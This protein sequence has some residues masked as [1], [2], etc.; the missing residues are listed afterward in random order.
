M[1][2]RNFVKGLAAS[3]F[4]IHLSPKLGEGLIDRFRVLEEDLGKARDKRSF[5]RRVRQEFL[6]N[7]DL[8]YLNCG[9]VGSSPRVVVDA[10][11][12]YMYE[13]EGDPLH[14]EWG[15]IGAWMEDVRSRAAE[16]IGAEEREIILTRNTTEGMNAVATGL[17]LKAGDEVL[18]T[19]HEHG[20]GMVCWQYLARHFGV[21]VRYIKMPDPV[22]NKEQ[23]LD[24]VEQ[25][26]T[27]KT[28]V[29]SFSHVDTITGLQMPIA[30]IARITRARDILLVC[31]GAQAPGMLDVDVM[32]LGVDTYASSSQKWMLS[33]KGCGLLY[34]R[35]GVQDRVQPVM[36]YD[37]Y[38][39]YTASMGTRNVPQ[40]LGHGVAMDFHNAIGRAHVEARIRQLNSLM[41]ERLKQIPALRLLTPEQPELSS[42]MVT[43]AV[44][45][46]KGRNGDI[47]NRLFEVHNIIVKPAQGTYAYVPNPSPPRENYNALRF[48]THI[49]NSEAQIERTADILAQMLT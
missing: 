44:D 40:I 7:P 13:M 42:G 8:V 30:D 16:F 28:R 19:N 48:S 46:N 26:I 5:W 24:L 25:H 43:F 3:L 10:V 32:A 18:T 36:L 9:S 14:N 49:F 37:G 33:P 15:G 12:N 23:I 41:R 17:R 35:R 47:A 34:I 1:E 20:G 27:P 29:C 21:K 11:A 39:A 45:P 2:R 22:E 31:D 6:L 38:R 4:A